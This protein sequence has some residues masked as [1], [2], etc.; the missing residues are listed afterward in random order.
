ME[1]HCT[2]RFRKVWLLVFLRIERQRFGLIWLSFNN[3]LEERMAAPPQDCNDRRAGASPRLPLSGE[4]T[5][6][7][8]MIST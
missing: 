7:R 2:A 3:T 5:L 6:K 1:P 8:I 4:P